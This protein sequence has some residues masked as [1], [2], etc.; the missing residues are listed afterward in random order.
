[1]KKVY[2]C[3]SAGFFLGACEEGAA[4]R[5]PAGEAGLLPALVCLRISGCLRRY[6]SRCMRLKYSLR[7]ASSA[8]LRR[9]FLRARR[10]LVYTIRATIAT[11]ST[12][13]KSHE[14]G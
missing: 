12:M 4:G 13:Y 14:M 3:L 1:M 10:E 6:S 7:F 5:L 11:A 9:L 2:F 8:A